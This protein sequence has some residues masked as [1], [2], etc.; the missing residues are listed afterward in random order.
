VSDRILVVI[1]CYN[2]ER[3]IGRVLK[4]FR[5]VPHGTFE[6]ILVLDN[7]SSDDTVRVATAAGPEIGGWRVVVARN[8]Q[9][10]NLGGSHKAAFAYAEECGFSHVVVLHGDD[11]GRIEDVLPLLASGTHRNHDAC[12]GA[13]FMAGSRIEGYSYFRRVG[14]RVFNLIFSLVLR[15]RIADLGSGLNLFGRAVFARNVTHH[16]PDDLH[17]NP[18]LLLA[19]VD[20]R[21]RILFFPITWR[22]EDQVSNVR[23][24]SQA[25]RTLGAAREY[26]MSRGSLREGE[27]RRVPRDEYPFDVVARFEP[28]SVEP[29]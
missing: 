28:A 17:F 22:E 4:Q 19:M 5:R 1:P 3:Q 2:C 15:R 12:L 25:V 29:T 24:A 10:Y 9:N 26:A 7:R 13:R 16:L 11:Q 8:R 6:E 21:F 23:M 14:N 18:Y 20:R 27:H